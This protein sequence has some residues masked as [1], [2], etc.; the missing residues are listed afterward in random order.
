[1]DSRGR[2]ATEIN[3]RT[4]EA[5]RADTAGDRGVVSARCRSA[6]G[7]LTGSFFVPQFPASSWRHCAVSDTPWARAGL[8]SAQCGRISPKKYHNFIDAGFVARHSSYRTIRYLVVWVVHRGRNS[9]AIVV[10]ASSLQRPGGR[11]EACTTISATRESS[12]RQWLGVEGHR[13]KQEYAGGGRRGQLYRQRSGSSAGCIPEFG[14][15]HA[16]WPEVAAERHG[17]GCVA[18]D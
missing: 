6:A 1:M 13:S 7:A 12:W 10:R 8:L 4:S 2:K 18:W 9:G 17:T 15:G 5:R 16:R 3:V 14:G 11:L